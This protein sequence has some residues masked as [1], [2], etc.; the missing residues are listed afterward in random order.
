MLIEPAQDA[1]DGLEWAISKT[2][3]TEDLDT[4]AKKIHSTLADVHEKTA[5]LPDYGLK[6]KESNQPA[7]APRSEP[8][9]DT[10]KT[11]SGLAS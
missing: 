8:A 7:Q 1:P 11:V 2:A 6:S 3:G 9:A 4:P 5:L 10:G